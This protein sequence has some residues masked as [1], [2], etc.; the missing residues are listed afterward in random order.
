MSLQQA[1]Y[2][3]L[4][5]A[6]RGG[7]IKPGGRVPTEKELA[8][9]F[10]ASRS[11]VQA[12]MSR[13]VHEGVVRRYAGRGTYA[14]R[15]DDDMLVKVNLDIHNI[16]SFENEMKVAGD[17]VTYRLVSFSKVPA[18]ARAAGKLGIE[19]GEAVLALYRLR[20]V[21]DNCIGSELRYFAPNIVLDVPVSALESQGVHSLIEEGLGI[22]IGR[23]EAV[24]RA[25]S[26]TDAQAHD[27]GVGP[28]SPL[29][30]RSHT[31]FDISDSVILHGESFYVEPFSF[32]YTAS[33]RERS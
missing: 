11:T 18:P 29:L 22:E 33:L 7:H 21:D 15:I 14:C 12:A 6:I 9:Q 1:I 2:D 17:R 5:D 19:I 16:Q 25:V 24:L 31:L 4:V 8:A 3:S 23:I 30:V 32:R 10:Q 28:G 13:L 26:A 27:L 20:F